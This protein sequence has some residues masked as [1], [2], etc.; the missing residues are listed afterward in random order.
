MTIAMQAGEFLCVTEVEGELYGVKRDRVDT[1]TASGR[2]CVISCSK[3]GAQAIRKAMAGD[4]MPRTLYLHPSTKEGLTAHLQEQ[5]VKRG[6]INVEDRVARAEA[7]WEAL[8]SGPK[9]VFD[10]EMDIGYD[11]DEPFNLSDESMDELT[12]WC[13]GQDWEIKVDKDMDRAA[14]KIQGQARR[15]RDAQKVKKLQAE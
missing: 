6:G 9:G 7:N 13:I 2:V 8:C 1:V 4:L 14:V 5:D 11:E 12:K 15:R 3:L 10:Q